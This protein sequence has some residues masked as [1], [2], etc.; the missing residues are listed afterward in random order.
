MHDASPAKW[1][2]AH[3]PW[4]FEQF[5]LVEH[6]PGYRIFHADYAY[7]FNSYY[8]SAGPRHARNARG[9]LTRPGAEEITAYRRHVDA[10]VV[11]FFRDSSEAALRKLAPLVEVGLNHE[12]QHQE[13]LLT[14]ILHAFAQNP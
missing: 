12:Q 9:L 3:T 1:H 4:F 8:V 6:C 10:A 11:K 13:F 5:L 14:D 2:P 7:L